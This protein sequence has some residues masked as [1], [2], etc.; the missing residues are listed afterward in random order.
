MGESKEKR[1][2]FAAGP[3]A[4]KET[5]KKGPKPGEEKDN[6][7]EMT[8]AE[9][10]QALKAAGKT[11]EKMAVGQETV[12]MT[13]VNAK[14]SGAAKE[15]AGKF[16]GP[17]ATAKALKDKLNTTLTSTDKSAIEAQDDAPIVTVN[18]RKYRVRILGG[19]VNVEWNV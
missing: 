1:L 7:M 3:E 5:E 6:T 15:V 2:V 14:L 11:W 12:D 19:G 13:G 9:G 8:K 4:P 10:A 17:E 16:L 18:S